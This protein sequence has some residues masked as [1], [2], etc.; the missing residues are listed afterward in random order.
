[1]PLK[2]KMDFAIF[3]TLSLAVASFGGCSADDVQLNGKI[4]DAAGLNTGSAPKKTP[5]MA[6][7]APLIVPPGLDK[8]PEPGTAAAASTGIEEIKDHDERTRV[9]KADLEKE[10]RE[11]CKVHYED[12]KIRGDQDYETAAGPLGRCRGSVLNVISNINKSDDEK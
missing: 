12:A 10:Q 7:R 11:Y 3:A 1:M 9:S 5:I 6:A 2:F 8:L 4:F